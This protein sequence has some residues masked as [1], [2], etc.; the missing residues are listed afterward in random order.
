MMVVTRERGD[1]PGCIPPGPNTGMAWKDYKFVE[2]GEQ[3]C[4]RL[5]K[6]LKEMCAF[7][8]AE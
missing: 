6:E 7:R 1:I 3:Y 4:K 2:T 5:A 8:G